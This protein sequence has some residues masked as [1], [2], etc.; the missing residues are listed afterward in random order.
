MCGAR[1]CSIYGEERNGAAADLVAVVVVAAGAGDEHSPA[2]PDV[3]VVRFVGRRGALRRQ[4]DG[5]LEAWARPRG[6]EADGE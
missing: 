3:A 2:G 1:P 4:A 5:R 6:G